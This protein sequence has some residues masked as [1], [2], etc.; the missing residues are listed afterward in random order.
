M[1]YMIA[2][3]HTCP[4]YVQIMCPP[5]YVAVLIRQNGAEDWVK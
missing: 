4:I 5:C 2:E 3:V 1:Q